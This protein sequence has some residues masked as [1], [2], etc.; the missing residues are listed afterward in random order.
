MKIYNF[1][2]ARSSVILEKGLVQLPSLKEFIYDPTYKQKALEH[3][4]SKFA[5]RRA[6]KVHK[7]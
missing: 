6:K 2:K 5:S 3:F 1:K 7:S 4:T